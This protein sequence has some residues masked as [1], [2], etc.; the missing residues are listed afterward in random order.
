MFPAKGFA[1]LLSFLLWGGP[2][3]AGGL[4]TPGQ[5]AQDSSG[6]VRLT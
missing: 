1:L 2:V 6:V 5:G 4:S 3:F